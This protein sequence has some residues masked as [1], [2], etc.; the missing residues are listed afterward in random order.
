MRNV[1]LVGDSV[2]D[3]EE[4]VQTGEP[5]VDNQFREQL[6]P[7]DEVFRTARDG[8]FLQDVPEQLL[9][10]PENTTHVFLS[11]GGADALTFLS[12]LDYFE[13]PTG[14]F[15]DG[16]DNF[17]RM[18]ES[19]MLKYRKILSKVVDA[20]P[21]TI[22][23]TVYAGNFDD[24]TLQSRVETVLPIINDAIIG[25]AYDFGL[26]LIELRQV[27]VHETDYASPLEPSV[28]GGE[29][30][31]RAMVNVLRRHDFSLERTSIYSNSRETALC[32]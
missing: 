27:F 12:R 11:T 31:S 15:G 13:K 20:C 16:V 2:F 22:P 4:Y 30:L 25:A 7:E 10:L 29:K 6:P 5:S 21:K 17:G 8:Y 24:Q 14:T 32:L 28:R 23:C 26:P 18:R 1:A 9:D 3:N 19:F